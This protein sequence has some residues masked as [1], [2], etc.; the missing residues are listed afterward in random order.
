MAYVIFRAA[1]TVILLL[2]TTIL[3]VVGVERFV[4]Y[5]FIVQTVMFEDLPAR[6]AFRRSVVLTRGRWWHTAV[7]SGAITGVMVWS[8]TIVSLLVLLGS[9]STPLW[10]PSVVSLIVTALIAP[11]GGIALAMLYGDAVAEE[12]EV[13]QEEAAT[14]ESLTTAD[15]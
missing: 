14:T 1:F 9:A 4:R 13:D 10:V 11:I 3:A 2:V 8:G 7:I 5:Q 15:T 12:R 6:A